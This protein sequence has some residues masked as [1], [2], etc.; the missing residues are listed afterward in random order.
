MVKREAENDEQVLIVAPLK[1]RRSLTGETEAK[2]EPWITWQGADIT[3]FG[4]HLGSNVWENFPTA[5]V[6]REQLPPIEA[7]R[8]ARAI[9]ADAPD[10]TLILPGNYGHEL[11]RHDLRTGIAP[12]VKVQVH[13][14]PRVQSIVEM[15][16]ENAMGQAAD[17]L[18]LVHRS[19]DNPGRILLISNIPVPGMVVD[20]L[21][22]LDDVLSGGTIWERALRQMA[23][24]MLPLSPDWLIKNL[25]KLFTSKR[26]AEMEVRGAKMWAR[27]H[28]S[29]APARLGTIPDECAAASQPIRA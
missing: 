12:A 3:H 9:W 6:F 21:M 14:D 4:R 23:C 25:S 13:P 8:I 11:R 24:G 10:V 26:L 17:R 18:R 28:F 29:L 7:E 16:R 27:L 15:Y 22:K 5:I 20:C 1:V 2:T 19:P